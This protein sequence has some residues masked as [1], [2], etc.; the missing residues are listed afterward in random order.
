M[1]MKPFAVVACTALAVTAFSACGD[2]DDD[3]PT[4]GS[5]PAA[6]TEGG[7]GAVTTPEIG[8]TMETTSTS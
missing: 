5:T 3:T 6:V 1:R 4:D 2:D 8:T 7:G